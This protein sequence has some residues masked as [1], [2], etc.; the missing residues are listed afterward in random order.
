[1]G[2]L[3]DSLIADTNGTRLNLPLILATVW[4]VK[5]DFAVYTVS[6]I[7][8]GHF[9]TSLANRWIQHELIDEILRRTMNSPHPMINYM[10]EGETYGFDNIEDFMSE[11]ER[12]KRYFKYYTSRQKSIWFIDSLVAYINF[13]KNLLDDRRPYQRNGFFLLVYTG[14][15]S[16]FRP[17]SQNIFRRL[18]HLYVTNVNILLMIGKHAYIY[19]YFPFR[20]NKC[21]SSDPELYMS[22]SGIENNRNFSKIKTVFYSKVDN[23]HRCP[24]TIITWNYHPYVFVKRDVE[25]RKLSLSGIEGSLINLIAEKMNFTI[26]VKRARKR[27]VGD[28]YRNGTAT[29]ALKMIV[30]QEG[31][32]TVLSYIYNTQRAAI[33]LASDSYLTIKYVIAIP[34]GRKLTPFERLT[35]PFH[36]VLWTC[37]GLFKLVLGESSQT[38]LT[39][40]LSTLFGISINYRIQHGNFA[41]YLLAL[42][43]MY[44]FVMRSVYS[45]ELFRILHD[46]SS[47]NDA[48]TIQDVV[49]DNYTIYTFTSIADV[50]H[51]IEPR[52]RIK[53]I[54]SVLNINSLLERVA[55]PNNKKR[56]AVCLS[57][58]YVKYYN[59]KNPRQRVK[60][61]PQPVIST[62]LI[63]YM[64]KHSY[65]KL[66]TSFLILGTT[67]AGLMT[68]YTSL[69]GFTSARSMHGRP[70][71]PTKLSLEIT[72][73]T[74]T[75]STDP[76]ISSSPL[77]PPTETFGTTVSTNETFRSGPPGVQCQHTSS[78]HRPS[79]PTIPY[80]VASRKQAHGRADPQINS[81]TNGTFAVTVC[82]LRALRPH[83]PNQ[84]SGTTVTPLANSGQ[85]FHHCDICGH[86]FTTALCRPTC[87]K[88]IDSSLQILHR[89]LH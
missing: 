26:K 12:Q 17:I 58:L 89:D 78:P 13:E 52:A 61:L 88:E 33:M 21:H 10:V 73:L 11:E 2:K 83:S 8:I 39:N 37:F 65:L 15:H 31:N 43:M 54:G 45:G 74:S 60:V 7:T 30:N 64:P 79:G 85:Q 62:P 51:H 75:V 40:L 57:D 14:Q 32:I 3:V 53:P 22:F 24:M 80:M 4:I 63:F 49:D 18:F 66:K 56:M 59:H 81:S 71:E 25:T 70:A 36:R 50:I 67:E 87:P 9:S 69:V 6:P 29:G 1:M 19:T 46:G 41:R 55:D 77:S 44:T 34:P 47:H 48:E 42:W 5:N 72:P 23:M 20:A 86:S 84:T 82:P 35:K 68:S 76:T 27:D 28:V 16:D 38:P